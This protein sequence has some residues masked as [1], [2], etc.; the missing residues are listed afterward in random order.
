[1]T[2]EINFDD[3]PFLDNLADL[4]RERTG[5]AWDEQ[6]RKILSRNAARR[7]KALKIQYLA[8][9][10]AFLEKEPDEWRRLITGLGDRESFFFRH[11]AQFEAL[12]GILTD[13]SFR[14]QKRDILVVSAGCATGEELYSAA[15]IA[16]ESGLINK[17]WSMEIYGLDIDPEAV[18]A[19]GAGVYPESSMKYVEPGMIQRYFRPRG[20]KFQVKDRVRQMVSVDEAGLLEWERENW[21][22]EDIAGK[23]D[24]LLV[25][26]VFRGLAPEAAKIAMDGLLNIMAPEGVII[27]SPL[28]GL[29]VENEK[30][31][32]ERWGGL[33]CYR[34]KSGKVKVNPGHVSR[35]ARRKSGQSEQVSE[36]EERAPV[37]PLR[38][39]SKKVLKKGAALAAEGD[40]AKAWSCW[41][42]VL[43]SDWEKGE[44]RPEAM[45]LAA[46]GFL[47][48]GRFVEAKNLA[49]QIVDF[50]RDCSWA[51]LLLAEACLGFGQI[52]QAREAFKRACAFPVEQELK[53]GEKNAEPYY[54]IDPVFSGIDPLER[55][56]KMIGE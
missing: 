36:V 21:L 37:F 48:M 43:D 11:P 55:V 7:C 56:G 25:R 26:N 33:I 10:L 22:G 23:A 2:E 12:S 8:D 17:G 30:L 16:L 13:L 18:Q 31:T 51:R 9:Y 42:S 45:G 40:Y 29:P 39:K 34:L 28:E 20:T 32:G 53:S 44:F 14:R 47:M 41:E 3:S 38:K 1:M 52:D 6:G 15:I 46:R 35:K 5:L 27:T 49:V 19:S 4:V 54:G 24:I 50:I